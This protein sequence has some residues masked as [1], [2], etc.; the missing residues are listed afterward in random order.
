MWHSPADQPNKVKNFYQIS[1]GLVLDQ[2]RIKM[3]LDVDQSSIN[4]FNESFVEKKLVDFL[5]NFFW[6]F[7]ENEIGLEFRE[8]LKVGYDVFGEMGCVF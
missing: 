7:R 4:L 6:K 8:R 1:K 3:F 5:M 2:N